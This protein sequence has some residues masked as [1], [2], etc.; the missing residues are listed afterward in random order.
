[1]IPTTTPDAQ[2]RL[3]LA[4]GATYAGQ[5]VKH[6]MTDELLVTIGSLIQQLEAEHR[7]LDFRHSF[8]H[9]RSKHYT[10]KQLKEIAEKEAR[11]QEEKQT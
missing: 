9:R 10:K 2:V 3:K 5:P 11:A 1:M 7:D 8:V 4:L 6:F